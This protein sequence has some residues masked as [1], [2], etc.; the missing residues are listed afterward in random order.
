MSSIHAWLS[1]GVPAYDRQ[2]AELNKA[3]GQVR[4]AVFDSFQKLPNMVG[5]TGAKLQPHR[6]HQHLA[7]TPSFRYFTTTIHIRD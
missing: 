6:T 4:D 2:V 5:K 1:N 3:P 7:L